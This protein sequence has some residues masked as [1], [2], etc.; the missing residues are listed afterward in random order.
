MQ[1]GMMYSS[2]TRIF[3]TPDVYMYTMYDRTTTSATTPLVD[4]FVFPCS[5]SSYL[6]ATV[7][8]RVLWRVR[9]V[10]DGCRLAG[11]SKGPDQ[12]ATTI[13]EQDQR[14]TTRSYISSSGNAWSV[15]SCAAGGSDHTWRH[16]CCW[17]WSHVYAFGHWG[18]WEDGN[19]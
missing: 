6:R 19:H 5:S 16:R 4:F 2:R 13:S 12:Q 14:A 7:L 11:K 1:A 8:P 3:V 18:G 17:S 15:L 9:W 10:T